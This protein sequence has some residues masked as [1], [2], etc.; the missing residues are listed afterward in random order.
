MG[1]YG[2]LVLGIVGLLAGFVL[3]FSALT[4]IWRRHWETFGTTESLLARL[5]A[6]VV[7]AMFAMAGGQYLFY[8]A[9]NVLQPGQGSF[10]PG[11]IDPAIGR[12]QA[13][14]VLAVA[15]ALSIIA[16]LRIE[17][18]HRRATGISRRGESEE[19]W[20]TEEPKEKR[21]PRDR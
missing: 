3:S 7:V 21:A 17:L 15:L 9:L 1:N 4:I 6:A 16:I 8:A 11:T 12:N 5:S 13:L 18:Y 2:G 20:Q 19:E 14:A 10:G